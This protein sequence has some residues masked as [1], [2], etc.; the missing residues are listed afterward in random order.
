MTSQEVRQ[1][2]DYH[3]DGHLLWKI[4][5]SFRTNIGDKAGSR[6]SQGYIQIS[7]KAKKYKAHRLI[8]MWHGIELG[9][10]VDHIDGNKT[11]NKIDNL[12][13]VSKNQNQWNSKTR[14]DNV[15]GVKGVRWHK[16]DCKW[17]V[18][19]RVNKKLHSFGYYD[20]LEL[21]ELVANEARSSYH[22]QYA[23]NN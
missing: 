3:Q 6:N 13:S 8:L 18:S 14:K 15:S 17:A 23:R 21:A 12:R 2:F 1:L 5:S 16:R 4:K 9:D 19:F 20:D 22:G 7:Y 11:N 10:E